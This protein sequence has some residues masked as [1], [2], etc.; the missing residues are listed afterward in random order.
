MGLDPV[1]KLQDGG[2][3]GELVF[4]DLVQQGEEKV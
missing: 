4:V 1:G 3:E 2:F